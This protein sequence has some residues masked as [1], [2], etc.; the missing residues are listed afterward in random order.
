MELT[1]QGPNGAVG[2]HTDARMKAARTRRGATS[3]SSP[4]LEG[5]ALV[6]IV[7]LPGPWQWVGVREAGSSAWLAVD[8]DATISSAVCDCSVAKQL[9]IEACAFVACM[10]DRVPLATF[11]VG[12]FPFYL[13][14]FAAK[15]HDGRR[16]FY[17]DQAVASIDGPGHHEWIAT[18]R[19]QA[20]GYAQALPELWQCEGRTA[21]N[22]KRCKF[23]G[24]R[25]Q[26]RGEI[27][28]Q[29]QCEQVSA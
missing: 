16:V 5:R 17:D 2:V 25:S 21:P 10:L 7:P 15:D 12:D 11:P 13:G 27:I 9:E 24:R 14:D 20:H 4:G 18:F 22:A 28:V 1:V 26:V 23:I 6:A 3:W 8:D 29:P 19:Q